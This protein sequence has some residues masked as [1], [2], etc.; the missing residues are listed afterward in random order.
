MIFQFTYRYYFLFLAQKPLEGKDLLTTEASRLHLDTLYSV[1]LLW[2]NDQ[3]DAD[4]YLTTNST[5]K[6]QTFTPPGGF[7]PAIPAKSGRRPTP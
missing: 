4:V 3:P 2:T 7:E 6:R 1:G 5:V